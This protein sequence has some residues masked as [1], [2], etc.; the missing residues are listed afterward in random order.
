MNTIVS[1]PATCKWLYRRISSSKFQ[2]GRA[3]INHFSSTSLNKKMKKEIAIGQPITTWLLNLKN[4]F[5]HSFSW[6]KET[7]G[8]EKWSLEYIYMYPLKSGGWSQDWNCYT[9]L[10]GTFWTPLLS[11]PRLKGLLYHCWIFW[12]STTIPISS[13]MYPCTPIL[14]QEPDM[15]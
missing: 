14:P 11:S 6:V 8:E 9:S 13:V 12:S 3:S 1:N 10:Q 5:T 4:L 15:W 2:W 7:L